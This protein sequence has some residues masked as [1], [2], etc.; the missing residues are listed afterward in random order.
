MLPQ[1]PHF[2]ELVEVI[3]QRA[4][5]PVFQPIIDFSAQQVLGFEATTRGALNSPLHSPLTM[6]ETAARAQLLPQLDR[7]CIFNACSRFAELG[8]PGLLFL[9]CSPVSFVA[10]GLLADAAAEAALG[11]HDL[12]PARI[13][14]EIT[15]QQPLDDF[16][17]LRATATAFRRR[18]FRIAVDDLGAGYAGLRFWNELK[19][20]YVKIDR[21]FIEGIDTDPSKQD[22]VRSIVEISRGLGC[23]AMG[24]GIETAEELETVRRLGIGFGQGFLLGLPRRIPVS[25]VPRQ[26]LQPRRERSSRLFAKATT[27]ELL[28]PAPTIPSAATAESVLD[29][30]HAD[31]S[32]LALPV[33]DDGLPVGVVTRHELLDL[34]S[35]RYRRELHGRKPIS[36]FVPHTVIVEESTS[37]DETSRLL[38]ED[39][40]RE[41]AQT[42]IITR[43][44]Q[45]LGVGQTRTLLRRMSEVQLIHARHS[46]PLTL[47]PGAVPLN[48]HI[49]TLLGDSAMFCLAY[50]DLNNFKP[51]N[52]VYGY[53]RGDE[54]ILLLARLLREHT[55]PERDFVGHIG[56]DDFLLV[57]R[58]PDWRAR[59]G[60]VLDRFAEEV[61]RCYPAEAL[62]AGGIYCE[63][64]SGRREYFG[65]LSVA[66]GVVCLQPAGSRS[67]DE[68]VALAT[69]AKR[70]AKRQA[71]NTIFVRS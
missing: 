52:D 28:Q 33:V 26:L 58:S 35:A 34:F 9:N 53:T 62:D 47:L 6:F 30:F 41:L 15:E 11:I 50:F 49:E 18:G 71:G 59:C 40:E 66:V 2:A 56:G 44:G 36:G 24:E 60:T 45:Y 21:H 54:V 57:L 70:E 31:R 69:A 8:L 13:V 42:F 7:A 65:L 68:L 39:G 23:R 20:D 37:L 1:P 19:P 27:G 55:D 12:P 63:N 3:E 14:I 16:G 43:Q 10:A 67:P 61:R 38:T 4:L 29:R 25:A 51:F 64:R 22:F 32:L 46:N 48:E 17:P 5:T